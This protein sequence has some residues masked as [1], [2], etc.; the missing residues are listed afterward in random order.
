MR[1]P[2][3]RDY[4]PLGAGA[5]RITKDI[6]RDCLGTGEKPCKH[7]RFANW[8]EF[9]CPITK[10][11]ILVCYQCDHKKPQEWMKNNFNPRIGKHNLTNMI[12][13]IGNNDVVVN[14]T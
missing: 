11:N 14:A 9:I 8:S 13:A 5:K 2:K 3:L 4:I 7:Y 6:C 12:Q 1:C 10:F